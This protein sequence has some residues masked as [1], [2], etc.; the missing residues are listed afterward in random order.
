MPTLALFI[1]LTACTTA[2]DLAQ[3]RA[4]LYATIHQQ[5]QNG[6]MS[7]EE[8]QDLLDFAHAQAAQQDQDTMNMSYHPHDIYAPTPPYTLD[9]HP[10]MPPSNIN[11]DNSQMNSYYQP[12]PSPLGMGQGAYGYNGTTGQAN[13]TYVPVNPALTPGIDA[14]GYAR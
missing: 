9:T 2:Q 3:S 10:S 1:T 12:G 5:V 6:T 13:T 14:N 8:G 4:N 7:P 11:I